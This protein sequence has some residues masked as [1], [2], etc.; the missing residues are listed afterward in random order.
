ME[1]AEQQA[2]PRGDGGCIGKEPETEATTRPKSK[3]PVEKSNRVPSAAPQGNRK[4]VVRKIS[5]AP[6]V[7]VAA[8]MPGAKGV[9]KPRNKKALLME[10]EQL[11]EM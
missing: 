11:K 8:G 10:V 9:R 6:S 2:E 5:I 4:P 3:P 1:E 7:K